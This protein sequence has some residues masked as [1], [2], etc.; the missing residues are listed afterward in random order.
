VVK[1]I[2]GQ[3]WFTPLFAIIASV[4]AL[5]IVAIGWLATRRWRGA[6]LV[7]PVVLMMWLQAIGVHGYAK[8][9][10]GR[11]EMRP[12]AEFVRE[13]AP[14]AQVYNYRGE[15]EEKRA[16]VDLA[17]YLNRST[18]SLRDSPRQE[19]SRPAARAR[20]AIPAQSSARQGLVLGV[21]PRVD[22][23]LR[24]SGAKSRDQLACLAQLARPDVLDDRVR[25]G[26]ADAGSARG[27]ERA[28]DGRAT[29]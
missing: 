12:L 27:R 11:S 20:L 6:M 3:P 29:R 17:I 14:N 16:P 4:I 10:E 8:S 19:G 13:H 2:D 28:R 24:G 1:T 25:A 23:P 9:R 7:T 22:C 5:A 15:R 18:S 26:T 21:R